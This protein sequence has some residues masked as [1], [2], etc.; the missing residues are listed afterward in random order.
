MKRHQILTFQIA[1]SV[2]DIFFSV[3]FMFALFQTRLEVIY[4]YHMS[5][6]TFEVV[7]WSVR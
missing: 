7:L 1:V 5:K 2:T 3:L 6:L 4:L